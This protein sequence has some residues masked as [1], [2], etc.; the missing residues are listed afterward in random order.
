M[1]LAQAHGH[2]HTFLPGGH[3][4]PGE[5]LRACLVREL[6]EETGR[7]FEVGA[8]LGVIE[9]EWQDRSGVRQHELNHLFAATS[10]G[11]TRLQTVT[12]SEP[13]LTFAWV[14]ASELKARQLM[15]PLLRCWLAGDRQ[16]RSSFASTLEEG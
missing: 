10:P 14:P 6:A 7:S 16:Q 11:L 13:H 12:S 1:L 2:A 8:F 4:E 5:G 3:V 15:P 9:Y